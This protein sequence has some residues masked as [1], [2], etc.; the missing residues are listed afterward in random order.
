MWPS[1]KR[2]TRPKK[3]HTAT[4]C[5][6]EQILTQH[7][8]LM[9]TRSHAAGVGD[10]HHFCVS[11]MFLLRAP[12]STGQVVALLQ[13]KPHCCT[14]ALVAS[15]SHTGTSSNG[16]LWSTEAAIPCAGPPKASLRIPDNKLRL[17]TLPLLRTST[18]GTACP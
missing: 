11:Y 6:A 1:R 4:G 17:W 8:L 13:R 16:L 2:T 5:K 9:E 12:R 7:R 14:V 3:S 18:A 15:D 10:S